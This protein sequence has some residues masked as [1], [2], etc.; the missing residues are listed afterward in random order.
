VIAGNLAWPTCLQAAR[1]VQLAA[2]AAGTEV[3]F[4]DA[5]GSVQDDI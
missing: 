4:H 3:Q 1:G 2:R 5:H